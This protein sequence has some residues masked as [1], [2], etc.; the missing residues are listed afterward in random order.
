MVF[1]E[2]ALS[3]GCGHYRCVE[4]FRQFHQLRG[5]LGV[6]HALTRVDYRTGGVHQAAGHSRGVHRVGGGSA[7]GDGGVEELGL[8]DFAVHHVGGGFQHHRARRAGTEL[9]EGAAQHLGHALRRVDHPGP[10]GDAAVVA[11]GRE[12]GGHGGTAGT[13]VSWEH[14]DRHTVGVRLG[15]SGEG[16]FDAG[17]GLHDADAGLVAVVDAAVGVGHVDGATL[18]AG[19][20]RADASGSDGVNQGVVGEAEGEFHTFLL[21]NV[22]YGSFTLHGSSKFVGGEIVL[23]R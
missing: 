22:C 12:V 8:I 5:G 18:H 11:G 6:Q 23:R 10:L 4:Q 3:E 17:A 16:V 1:G 9:G 19:D 20:D 13:L 7:L 15:D 21:E 14:Q 2:A